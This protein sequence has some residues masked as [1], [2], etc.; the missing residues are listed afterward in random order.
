M[1]F[2]IDS[3]P[4]S[5]YSILTS[6]MFRWTRK[7]III[8]A[9]AIA[10]LFF[11][12]YLSFSWLRANYYQNNYYKI[13]PGPAEFTLEPSSVAAGEKFTLAGTFQKTYPTKF[14]GFTDEIKILDATGDNL[15]YS[16]DRYKETNPTSGFIMGSIQTTPPS[17]NT[18]EQIPFQFEAEGCPIGLGPYSSPPPR[19]STVKQEFR[20]LSSTPAGLY[21][22][23]VGQG[24]F[25][26][27]IQN[28]ATLLLTV[29]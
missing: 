11:P 20:V 17:T 21:T 14:N 15:Y 1:K 23:V 29:R 13:K 9:V 16:Y 28:G 2:F 4:K 19:V 7:K 24:S 5:W 27:V 3:T 12:A 25:C 8:A 10:I 22:F 18:N 26:D 6:M